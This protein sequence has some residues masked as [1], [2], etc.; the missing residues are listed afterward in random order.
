[1]DVLKNLLKGIL[2]A[3]G[4]IVGPLLLLLVALAT[5]TTFPVVGIIIFILLP[6]IVV[7]LIIGHKSQKKEG[8]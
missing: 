1:M 6:G 7:G 8:S 3:I 5:L 4:C 2:I